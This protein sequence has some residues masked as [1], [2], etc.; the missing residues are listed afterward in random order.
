MS[1]NYNDLVVSGINIVTVKKLTFNQQVNTH[2]S[3]EIEV[4]VLQEEGKRFIEE[5]SE[6]DIITIG[7][8][9]TIFSG[10]IQKASLIHED[11]YSVLSLSLLSTSILWDVQK[12]NRSYQR[13]GATYS[14]IMTKAT[15][16]EGVIEFVGN[17]IISKTMVVQYQETAWEFILRLASECKEPV[18]VNP[19]SEIPHVII[20]VPKGTHT[21]QGNITTKDGTAGTTSSVVILGD[22]SGDGNIGSVTSS[23]VGGELITTYTGGGIESQIY[24]QK[25]YT[26]AGRVMS[27]IVK[28]VYRDKVKVHI[29]DL[30]AEY[31]EE[32]TMW[33]SY[34]TLYSSETNM[35]GIYCMPIVED[36]VRVFFPTENLQDAFVSSSYTVRGKASC[37]EEK[38][39]STPEGMTV[40]FG[41]EGLY[42]YGNKKKTGIYLQKDGMVSIES[43][44]DINIFAGK[45]IKMEAN[46]GKI[47]IKS[48]KSINF[49]VG[50]S[51]IS[52]QPTGV[53][54]VSDRIMTQ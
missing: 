37:K 41:K 6:Q 2:A 16:G 44:Q 48:S 13:I 29:T 32:S 42:I 40:L 43:E 34:S 22:S 52:M 4:E 9:Y 36:P 54:M 35:A 14:Q 28:D 19:A 46:E 24:P 5:A 49:G 33:F 45:N 17:D 23:I 38:L 51:L 53:V 10:V 50:N 3:A 18:Y 12:V 47:L 8:P 7:I 30:D 21:Q 25:R 39:F 11:V 26:F 15:N 27:G 1:I 20:G 31:D